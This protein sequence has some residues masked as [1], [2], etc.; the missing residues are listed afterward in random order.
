MSVNS[1]DFETGSLEGTVTILNQYANIILDTSPYAFEGDK[2]FVIKLRKDSVEGT[3]IATTP[4]ITIQDNATV[5]GLVSN[6]YRLAEGDIAEFTFTT[7][8]APNNSIL[9]Y[10][11]EPMT[12]NVTFDDFIRGPENELNDANIF[13]AN[14]GSFVVYNNVGRFTLQANVGGEIVEEGEKFRVQVRAANIEGPILAVSDNVTL[15][16]TANIQLYFLS[17]PSPSSIVYSNTI[18]IAV[19]TINVGD[20]TNLFYT[21]AGTVNADTFLSGNTG[22]ITI[23][24]GSGNIVLEG[25]GFTEAQVETFSLQLREGSV[26]GDILA[27]TDLIELYDPNVLYSKISGGTKIES[28]LYDIHVFTSSESLTVN[29]VGTVHNSIDYMLVGGGGKGGTGAAG[30][31]LTGVLNGGGGGGGVRS[32]TTPLINSSIS[33]NYTSGTVTVGAGSTSTTTNGGTSSL[34]LSATGVSQTLQQYGGTPGNNYNS[35]SR[36]GSS[37]GSSGQVLYTGGTTNAA[38]GGGGAGAGQNGYPGQ[39]PGP[40]INANASRGG[41]GVPVSWIPA[42]Y[43]TPGPAPGRWFGGG[44]V[45]GCKATVPQATPY[46]AQGVRT[47]AGG[48]GAQRAAPTPSTTWSG[49]INTGGGGGAG[50]LVQNPSPATSGGPGGSGIVAIRY[51]A[52]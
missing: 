4:V 7:Q 22:E 3:V 32:G 50:Q 23:N 12:A 43:G 19:T 44:G 47:G 35:P 13:L 42:S 9:F 17:T 48:G 15:L 2:R 25:N 41:N 52:R 33:R 16:D 39:T 28:G 40:S 29:R 46:F 34:I 6:T 24:S 8:N 1:N 37:L 51:R 27:T 11:V 30:F 49:Q 14:T 10:T 45:G 21:T 20:G 5:A 38:T 36:A 18:T 26:T 31:T